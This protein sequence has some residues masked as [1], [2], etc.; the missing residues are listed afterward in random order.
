MN[1]RKQILKQKIKISI[2]FYTL[3]WSNEKGVFISNL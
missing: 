3:I 2:W 1:D